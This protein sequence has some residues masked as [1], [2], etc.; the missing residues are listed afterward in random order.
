MARMSLP[1]PARRNILSRVKKGWSK[2][3]TTDRSTLLRHRNYIQQGRDG[4]LAFVYKDKDAPIEVIKLYQQRMAFNG[5]LHHGSV[6]E[7]PSGELAHETDRKAY[8]FGFSGNSYHRLLNI[9]YRFW[10]IMARKGKCRTPQEA[11]RKPTPSYY[12]NGRMLISQKPVAL[13]LRKPY[14]YIYIYTVCRGLGK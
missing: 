3:T 1:S 4:N 13:G 14:I 12:S 6:S 8:F 7:I 5:Y 2:L 9:I 11:V 10:Y